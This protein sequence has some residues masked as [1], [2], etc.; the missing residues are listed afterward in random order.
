MYMTTII[1]H[2]H[3]RSVQLSKPLPACM[4]AMPNARSVAVRT[5]AKP[6]PMLAHAFACWTFVPSCLDCWIA[7]DVTC[8]NG[9][10]CLPGR[11]PN[12]LKFS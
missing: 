9:C 7:V 5:R 1:I 6:N 3:I 12:F 2:L 10:D 8:Y 4:L 11:P